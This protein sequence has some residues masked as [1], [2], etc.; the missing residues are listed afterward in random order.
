[1]QGFMVKASDFNPS[2]QVSNPTRIHGSAPYK[3]PVVN[4]LLSI[5]VKGNDYSDQTFIHFNKQA[6]SDFDNQYD[7]YKR[8]GDENAPQLYSLIEGIKYSI[9]ELP[10]NELSSIPMGFQC[11]E[12]GNFTISFE[13]IKELESNKE[14]TLED[15]KENIFINLDTQD[16][17]T[18]D[19]S[20]E[21]DAMRFVL[22]FGAL[23]EEEISSIS[24]V[25]V[26]SNED[27]IF[28]QNPSNI[29]GVEMD[30]MNVSGQIIRHSTLS[31][32]SSSSLVL[33]I[34]AAYYFVRLQMK[35]N[36]YTKKLFVQ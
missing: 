1:M 5:T 23:G 26:Y 12:E 36:V 29:Q 24:M 3:S 27:I 6:T 25:E 20:T 30:I 17:Y 8:F 13:G 33:D 28:I 7:A 11:G 19:A 10:L 9:N 34:P 14:V 2:L 18:F 22:H 15:L 4:N 35:D 31:S 32:N 21:D 16:S